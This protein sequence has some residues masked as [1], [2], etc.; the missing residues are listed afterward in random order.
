MSGLE[1]AVAIIG[2]VSGFATAANSISHC[3]ERRKKRKE[4]EQRCTRASD[5]D[6]NDPEEVGNSLKCGQRDVRKEYDLGLAGLGREF[7]RGD[8]IGVSQLQAQVIKLQGTIIAILG[9]L[10]AN[11]DAPLDTALRHSLAHLF[12]ASEETRHEALRTMQD[13]YQR[14]CVK[15]PITRGL[16]T[17]KR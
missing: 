16:S 14:P 7:Q 5:D 10:V 12:R 9:G 2:I 4:R 1:F 8:E 15:R 17:D 3:R 13:Q 11:P 6:D